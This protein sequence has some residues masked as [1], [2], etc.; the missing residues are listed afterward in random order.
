MEPIEDLR[1]PGGLTVPAAALGWSF[2]RA[3]GP[4]GQYVNKTSS[5]VTL[6]VAI[7]DVVGWPTRLA[8][9]Q[10]AFGAEVR[11]TSQI[12]RSQWRNR[13][14]CRERLAQM[15]DDAARPPA[16]PR[17]PSKPKRSAVEERLEAKRRDGEKK[18]LRRGPAR[19]D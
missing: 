11:V 18:A 2:A 4:G 5:K 14:E 8:R 1:T 15:L 16:P 12:H 10:A 7:D 17:R 19:D 3:S 9:L 6:T 13:Q